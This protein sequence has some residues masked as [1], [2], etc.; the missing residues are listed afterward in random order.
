MV[1]MI[2]YIH[3]FDVRTFL[4]IFDLP[5]H[6]SLSKTARLISFSADGWFYL[7]LVP[8]IV[9]LRQAESLALLKLAAIGFTI[10]RSIYFL[11]KNT[12]KRRRPP[13]AIH[14]FQA[15]ITASD[16]FSLPSGHTS[17]AFFFTTF[18]CLALTPLFALLY[19]WAAAV[20]ASRVILGVHFPTDILAGA[21]LG[22]SLAFIIL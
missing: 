10:E 6:P 2:R 8:L 18:L 1:R 21:T 14:G 22:T 20:G 12:I 7:L 9:W 4:S 15:L 19:P 5:G 11:L 13:H 16:E 17:A 3:A